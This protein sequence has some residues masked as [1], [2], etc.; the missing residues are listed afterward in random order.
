[1]GFGFFGTLGFG[2]WLLELGQT[3]ELLE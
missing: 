3:K 2:L 1:M